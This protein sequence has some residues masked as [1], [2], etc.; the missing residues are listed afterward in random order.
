MALGAAS[1]GAL[2]MPGG[3]WPKANLASTNNA[4]SHDQWA[5]RGES[6]GMMIR[7]VGEKEDTVVSA[8]S[9]ELSRYD[10]GSLATVEGTA[11]DVPAA[12]AALVTAT[13]Q[14]EAEHHYSESSLDNVVVVQGNL[15]QAAVPLV[16]VLCA[17]LAEQLP[18]AARAETL[19]LVAEI[20]RGDAHHLEVEAGRAD[21]PERAQ[22]LARAALWLFY[23]ELLHGPA[24]NMEYAE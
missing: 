23:R 12:V 10:W 19:R 24:V 14:A 9:V 20:V 6:S 21:L 1:G 16:S 8:M 11:A 22:E 15:F 13:T 5:V 7:P 3:S 17:A 2:G 4:W 18:A